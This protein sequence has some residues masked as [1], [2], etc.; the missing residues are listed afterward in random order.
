MHRHEV[1]HHGVSFELTLGLWLI[2]LTGISNGR[3]KTMLFALIP[4]FNFS[5][6]VEVRKV[7]VSVLPP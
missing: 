2:D 1:F 5:T 3:M 6:T 7:N 4:A